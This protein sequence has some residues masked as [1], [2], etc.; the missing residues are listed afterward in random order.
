VRLGFTARV[1]S[2]SLRDPLSEVLGVVEPGEALTFTYEDAVKLAGHSCPTIAGAY[3]VT[4]VALR[5]LYGAQL[6]VRGEIEVTVGAPRDRG[7]TGP[8]AQVISLLTG[9]AAETGFHGLFGRFRRKD[10][11]RFDPALDGRFRFRR[12]DTGAAVDVSYDP[13]AAPSAP[14]LPALLTATLAG[15]ATADERRRTGD[16]WQARVADILTGDPARVVRVTPAH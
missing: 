8:M 16:L 9:A 7:G 13:S 3:L 6:P 4:A 10:L 14:E 11:L 15:T 1:A 5:A 2:L 12:T